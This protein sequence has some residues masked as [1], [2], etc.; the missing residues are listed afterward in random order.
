[1][2]FSD[3][4]ASLFQEKRDEIE[5]S[6]STIPSRFIRISGLDL[7]VDLKSQFRE[8]NIPINGL[9]V[10]RI[11]STANNTEKTG[12][13]KFVCDYDNIYNTRNFKALFA[14]DEIKLKKMTSSFYL[15][16][17]VQADT[18][19]DIVAYT[20]VEYNSGSK[21]VIS[22]QSGYPIPDSTTSYFTNL[23][24]GVINLTVP[25][26]KYW[27]IGGTLVTT[28]GVGIS[29]VTL[30]GTALAH[31]QASNAPVTWGYVIVKAGSA[32]SMTTSAASN[33]QSF[34]SMWVEEFTV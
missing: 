15:S 5:V 10:E 2:G 1:M 6:S 28:T 27:R 23:A 16:W 29:K 8:Y 25:S 7:S 22:Q 17:D 33:N 3:Y 12:T 31:A 20:D 9:Q 18:S 30:N 14:Y 13:I 26:G 34:N 19:C 11:Y 21:K 4:V 32:I 24:A